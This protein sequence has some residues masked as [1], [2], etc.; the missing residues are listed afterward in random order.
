VQSTQAEMIQLNPQQYQLS[1]TVDFSTVPALARQASSLL[2][3]QSASAI[4]VDCSTI[5][6]SNSAGLAL[7]LELVK[8]AKAHN[9]ELKFKNLPDT[10]MTIAKAY[11]VESEIRDISQ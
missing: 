9:V 6:S 3:Q 2:K 1:G 7:M 10:L 4:E 11:G 5:T 8:D